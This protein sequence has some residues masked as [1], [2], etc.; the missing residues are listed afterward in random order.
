MA[1]PE[2]DTWLYGV[3]F[4]KRAYTSSEF[5]VAAFQQLGLFDGFEIN[6]A[7]FTPKDVYEL[8]IYDKEFDKPDQCNESDIHLPFCQLMG[9]TRLHLNQYSTKKIFSRMNQACGNV[10][11]T[12][13]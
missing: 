5:V 12:G 11:V 7:E 4:S 6:A 8:D 9:Q 3:H 10:F 13:I 2:Q 1:V